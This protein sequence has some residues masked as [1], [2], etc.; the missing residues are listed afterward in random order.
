MYLCMF[1]AHQKM[2]E[3]WSI[4]ADWRYVTVWVA[5]VWGLL[6]SSVFCL[7]PPVSKTIFASKSMIFTAEEVWQKSKTRLI[8]RCKR[9]CN[10]KT[11]C[12]LFLLKSLVNYSFVY[13]TIISGFIVIS[14][15]GY[16]QLFGYTFL[17]KLS[18]LCVQQK[19]ETR[20]GLEQLE[21]D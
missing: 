4:S 18:F 5:C 3:A 1:S 15:N 13:K 11:L 6:F 7:C 14:F 19:R 20:T 12:T 16:Q 17:I 21:G 10:N 9:T 2:P 8:N